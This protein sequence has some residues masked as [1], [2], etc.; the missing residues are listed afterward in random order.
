MGNLLKCRKVPKYV[1][2]CRLHKLEKKSEHKK[3]NKQAIT[4]NSKNKNYNN[5]NNNNKNKSKHKN[6]RKNKK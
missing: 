4:K 2:D 6:K 5:K 3:I 1:E